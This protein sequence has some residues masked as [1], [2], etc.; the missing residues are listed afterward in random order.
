VQSFRRVLAAIRRHHGALLADPV[1]TGKTYVALAVAAAVNRGSTACL[2]PAALM[3]QWRATA[4]RLSVPVTL[5][6]HEQISRG[7]LPLGTRGL[8]LID[9]SHHL[10][11]PHTRR[12]R[13]L[14]PWLVGRAALLITATPI[15]NH[16]MDLAHQ[17]RLTIRDDAL[18]LD[19]VSSLSAM[20]AS[21]CPVP[22]LGRL[23]LE[24]V[25][26]QV[27]RPDRIHRNS[28][29]SQLED[30]EMAGALD[31]LRQLRLSSSSPVADLIRGVL[32]RSL[33]SSPAAYLSALRRYRALLLQARDAWQAGHALSRTALRRFTADMQDQL[34]FW[35]LLPGSEAESD[36]VLS[37]LTELDCLIGQAAAATL[38]EDGKLS[39]LQHLLADGRPTLVFTSSRETVRYLRARLGERRIAWCTGERSGIGISR[40][41]RQTVLSWFRGPTT[42]PHAPHHLIVTDVAAEGLD[43]QRPDRVVH[44]DLPWTPMRLEQ[45]EGRAVRY[46][47][48]HAEV[49]IV[50]FRSPRLLERELGMEAILARKLELPSR[51]GIGPGGR[52]LWGWRSELA[53][54]FRGLEAQG[55]VAT[56]IGKT[57]GLLAGFALCHP[58][59]PNQET[60]TVLWLDSNGTWT[61]D[62]ATIEAQLAIAA[63]D[64]SVSQPNSDLLSGWLSLLTP[65]MRNRLASTRSRRWV[66]AQPTEAVRR[67][68][69]RLQPR[70]RD[71]A[72]RHDVRALAQLEQAL[73]FVTS[74]HTAGEAALIGRLAGARES[75]LGRLLHTLPTREQHRDGLEVRLTGLI[76]FRPA[77]AAAA[78]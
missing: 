7:R 19:G 29:A 59:Q 13:H 47:S 36:L 17:L 40:L 12:Y 75:E 30:S 23:V 3:G 76:V 71:S 25:G 4:D 5:C 6:S 72:R 55:G 41:P 57:P 34:V 16:L 26:A 8:V 68:M 46:G 58:D 33:A 18:S 2:V 74:G 52:H 10:R 37:D 66:T 42:S 9:E 45:R 54:R 60:A 65:A 31:R 69:D 64:G 20:L 43:L 67:V 53:E 38:A 62:P 28:P 27:H 14:A 24:R 63:A 61:E 15:V 49:E 1:G 50:Q 73:A 44:Y 22:A 48:T 77:P 56:V 78:G 11:N 39:R 32:L 51:A 21:E 35:D 70:I